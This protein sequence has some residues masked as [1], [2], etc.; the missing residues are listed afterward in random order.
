[1]V[2]A[3]H[4]IEVACLVR[5]RLARR[6]FDAYL[7]ELVRAAAPDRVGHVGGRRRR[8][9]AHQP[10]A[11]V[12][13]DGDGFRLEK[14]AAADLVRRAGG[15]SADHGPAGAGRGRATRSGARARSAATSTRSSDGH[16][17]HAG[18]ARH[19]QP[20]LP[21]H[22][23]TGGSGADPA[24]PVRGHR[25][26]DHGPVLAHPVGP[27]GWGSRPTPSTARG[28]S[29]AHQARQR[30]GSVPADRGPARRSGD[31]LQAMRAGGARRDRRVRGA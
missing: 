12:Q 18:H 1:M 21:R 19:V 22:R 11:A 16:V 10:V 15:R 24:R 23:R 5:A 14:E 27:S 8:R 26:R 17:G 6:I 28:A 29:C 20:R 31:Q 4:Q 7:A 30:P 3:M 9:P 2:L 25:Q 13:A